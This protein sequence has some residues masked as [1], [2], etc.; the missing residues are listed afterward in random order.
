MRQDRAVFI[1]YLRID[2]VALTGNTS[3]LRLGNYMLCPLPI[4]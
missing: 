4:R 1:A 2:S 3:K